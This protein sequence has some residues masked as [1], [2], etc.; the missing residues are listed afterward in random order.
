MSLVRERPPEPTKKAP[1]E[2]ATRSAAPAS[3]RPAPQPDRTP[4]RRVQ[5][6]R[7]VAPPPTPLDT[8]SEAP[9]PTTANLDQPAIGTPNETPRAIAA[10]PP[11]PAPPAPATRRDDAALERWLHAVAGRVAEHRRYPSLARRLRL[12][13]EVV[14]SMRVGPAGSLLAAN[15]SRTARAP[16]PLVGAALAAVRAGAPYPSPPS[17]GSAL[18]V[19]VPVRF[20]LTRSR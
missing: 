5:R 7:E 2:A 12:E 1:P 18:D 4:V 14:V 13:G 6:P 10:A 9:A 15:T 20:S 16:E 8:V 11:G 19:D 17:G 3:R